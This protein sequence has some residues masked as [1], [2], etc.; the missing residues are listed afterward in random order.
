MIRWGKTVNVERM[1]EELRARGITGLM[2]ENGFLR[3]PRSEDPAVHGLTVE[4]Q[5]ALAQVVATHDPTPRPDPREE[6]R[7][8][9]KAY[10]QKPS[11]TLP[12]DDKQALRD[13]AFLLGGP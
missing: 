4:E 1:A 11:P 6:A 10:S 13:V 8:R 7:A 2:D 3:H 12:A 5:Q 9:L